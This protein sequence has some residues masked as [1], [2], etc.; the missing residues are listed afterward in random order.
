MFFCSF[1]FKFHKFIIK[2][3]KVRCAQGKQAAGVEF[4]NIRSPGFGILLK[5]VE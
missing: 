5:S 4:K 3:P 2:I 1:V